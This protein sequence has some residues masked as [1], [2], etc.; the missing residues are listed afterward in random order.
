MYLVLSSLVVVVLVDVE[1]PVSIYSKH[2]L[3]FLLED[4]N[5][6]NDDHGADNGRHRDMPRKE[7][8]KLRKQFETIRKWS[9]AGRKY[10]ESIPTTVR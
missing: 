3:P 4:D 6:K 10:S 2:R 9:E 7:I 5:D 8:T 1:V